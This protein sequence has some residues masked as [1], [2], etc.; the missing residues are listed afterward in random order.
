[1]RR[2]TLVLSLAASVAVSAAAL[3]ASAIRPLD[4]LTQFALVKTDAS[5]MEL[6]V[7]QAADALKDYDVIFLGEIHDHP[8]A[9]LAELDAIGDVEHAGQGAH[10]PGS[11]PPRQA[12]I[13]DD[14]RFRPETVSGL[15]GLAMA[16]EPSVLAT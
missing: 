15:V 8:G 2:K 10:G 6:S 12:N 14:S 16:P 11:A 9:H 7:D 1:M 13:K 5:G 4:D 3:A